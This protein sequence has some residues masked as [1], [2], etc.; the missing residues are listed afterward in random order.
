LDRERAALLAQR[1][2]FGTTEEQ[3]DAL[4]E[5]A[6]VVRPD[7]DRIKAEVR[8]EERAQQV[9]EQNLQ[10]IGRE[11][12]EVFN[13]PV[14]TQVAALQL[15]NLRGHPAAGQMTELDQYR[16][17]C[18]QVRSR[19]N[20]VPQQSAPT[21]QS[22]REPSASRLERK[23]NAP[24]IP[25]GADHRMTMQEAAPREPTTSEVVAQI[26]KARGQAA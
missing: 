13:D 19:F 7:V 5:F 10:I 21:S 3:A 25:G 20:P 11:Y 8:A 6:E 24:S 16:F 1:L 22:G 12:P 15:H 14:L 23:R 2:S 26:R 9:L 17:A 4:Q 18:S